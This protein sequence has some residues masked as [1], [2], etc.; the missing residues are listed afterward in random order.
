MVSALHSS[1][2][3]SSKEFITK[4]S[5]QYGWETIEAVYRS[6]LSRARRGVSRRVPD[7]KY[8]YVERDAWTKLNVHPAKIMQVYSLT[9]VVITGGGTEY[10]LLMHMPFDTI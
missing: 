8:S 1:R 4:D 9:S 7:L 2:E 5:I 6:D 3:N 10:C